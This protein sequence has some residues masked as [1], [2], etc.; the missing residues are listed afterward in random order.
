MGVVQFQAVGGRA[1]GQGRIR[2]VRLLRPAQD[3]PLP[4]RSQAVRQAVERLAGIGQRAAYRNT[5]IVEKEVFGPIDYLGRQAVVIE[6]GT[7]CG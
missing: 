5:Q 7:E 1:V 6:P 4:C 3:R 2:E